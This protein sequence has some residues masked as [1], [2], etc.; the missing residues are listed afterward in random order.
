MFPG[1][2]LGVSRELGRYLAKLAVVFALQFV[3]GK[4]GDA[5][6]TINSGGIGPVWP[7]S[8]IALGALLVWG[9]SV[10]PGIAGGAFLLTLL[11]G[12]PLWAAAAY[13]AGT[14]L[15]AL[16]PAF[17]LR[18]TVKFDSA[19]SHL[20]DALGLIGL[21]AFGGSVVSASIGVPTLYAAHIFGWSGL[22]KAWL[23]YWLGDS[24]GVLVVT[25]LVLT[26]PTLLRVQDKN[27]LVE[28]ALLLVLLVA[29]CFIVFGILPIWLD[30]LTFVVLPFVMWAALRFGTGVTS[31]SIFLLATITTVETALGHGPFAAYTPVINAALL[32]ALIGVVAVTG[33]TLAAVQAEREQSLRQQAA[34]ETRLLDNEAI[35]DSEDKLRLILDSTAEAIYGVDLEDRCTFC[36]PA[37]LRTLGY[38]H[39]DE[40]LGK[41]MHNLV[42]HTRADGR[43]LPVEECRIHRAAQTGEGIHA[44]DEVMWR[45]DGT[46]FP[47]EYW[48]Y[49]Q[50]KRNKIVGAVVA[51]L[52][53]TERKRAEAA[54]ANVSRKLIE[55]QER[56][57]KRIAAELH[58]SLGQ[59]LVVIKNLALISLKNGLGE[60]RARAQIDEISAEA[61]QAL[62]EVREISY[63]LRPYQLDRLGL[64]K[65]IEAIV[66]KASWASSIVFAAEIAAIDGLFPK[67][68]EIHFYRIVQEW[69]N[70]LVKHSQATEARVA[71]RRAAG[72]LVLTIRDNGR[73]F[74]PEA[75]ASDRSAGGFGLIG[76]SERAQ[77]LGGKLAIQ[78]AP[79]QGAMINIDIPIANHQHGE[80]DTHRDRG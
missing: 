13:A 33:L 8:G 78:S 41:K 18:R 35:R 16:L 27:R 73:G 12:L 57:R 76:L 38:E 9:C 74:T 72:G 43:A 70:N 80:R 30:I 28:L 14:T 11:G 49:P 56:E 20:G 42:H 51:F 77:L 55:A 34:M 65:A 19:V 23:I 25:P 67:D 22:G 1:N 48:S 31:L 60:G 47:V 54:V 71:V 63:N 32:G 3:G 5:L 7:A 59:H 79:G 46:C 44:A 17:L 2:R 6:Y 26:L 45:A 40:L 37:C 29:T 53:I 68:S 62:S 50:R 4:L 69:V 15:A 75:V 36:N 24:T 39:G 10:W 66:K 58:D 64:T 61:S 52:D 21:G